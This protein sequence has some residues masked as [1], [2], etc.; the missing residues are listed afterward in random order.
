MVGERHQAVGFQ[1]VPTRSNFGRYAIIASSVAVRVIG[2]EKG[3][4]ETNKGTHVIFGVTLLNCLDFLADA[5][6]AALY[7]IEAQELLEV[8]EVI[9]NVDTAADFKNDI[10][11]ALVVT[12][13]IAAFGVMA[14]QADKFIEIFEH[15]G[16]LKSN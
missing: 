5:N 4:D 10:F 13:D 6:I 16:C 11:A 3:I 15:E 2:T 14:E 8:H 7:P 12:Y 1:F 9:D